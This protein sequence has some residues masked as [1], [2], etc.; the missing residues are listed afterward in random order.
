MVEDNDQEIIGIG[1]ILWDSLP[2]GLFL[3]GAPLNVC[4]HLHHL[5]QKTAIVGRVGEDRLGK[6]ALRRIKNKGLSTDLIQI[7]ENYETGFVAVKLDEAG[8]P[9]YQITEP[10]AWD[11]ITLQ[12]A[13]TERLDYA[14]GMIFGSLAQR[15]KVSRN[16]IKKL[17]QC[18]CNKAFDINLR[19]PFID[20][21][22]IRESLKAADILKINEDELHQLS[23]WFDLRGSAEDVVR[24]IAQ[25]F[26]CPIITVTKA[27][28]GAALLYNDHWFHHPGF[29][30]TESDAVG[31]G[32]AFMAALLT[33]IKAGQNGQDIIKY[34]NAVGAYVASQNGAI[35][36]YDRD[37]IE[38]LKWINK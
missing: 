19:P 5:S 31:A 16:T 29:K 2:S 11:H 26:E 30:I 28:N 32:D 18:K 9:N 24:N 13:L 25:T 1:E 8:N 6:E 23:K 3:G 10:V 14:W 17:V 21:E 33:G 15:N 27:S 22:I 38:Q 20:H 4:L 12:H 36:E 35:P 7:D 34:A 37:T